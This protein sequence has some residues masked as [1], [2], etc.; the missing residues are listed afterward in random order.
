[1]NVKRVGIVGAGTMGR[2]IA[3]A[4]AARGYEVL[5]IDR[6]EEDLTAAQEG[7]ERELNKH[8]QKWSITEAEKKAT[9]SRIRFSTDWQELSGCQVVIE[10]IWEVLP[11]KIEV[12]KQIETVAGDDVLIASNTSTL[13]I[14]EIASALRCPERFL[15]LHFHYPPDRRDLIELVRGLKT[16][17][18]TVQEGLAFVKAVG[19]TAIQVF[20]SPGYVT[21]RL[22]LPLINEAI[23]LLSEGV[24]SAEDIETAMKEGY[25]FH[26]GPLELA[27]R[28][29]LDSVLKTLEALFGE[30][31]DP[32]YR[33]TP[34]LRR[35]VRDKRH[36]VKTGEGIFRYDEW[37][38]RLT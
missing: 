15:G 10:A 2:G 37:G 31:A 11:D 17:E 19:M 1:M 12:L 27:D 4:I 32:K 26:A 5:L 6:T 25:G 35:L 36:G 21:A 14:T 24:A 38:N 28:F 23:A 33:P 18:E 34:Y 9:L 22:M 13:S 29:G 7:L 30:T 3:E 16:A 8:L 20:E